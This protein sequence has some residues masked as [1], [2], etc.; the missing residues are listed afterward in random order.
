MQFLGL[1]LFL[2][3]I[4][5]VVTII[6]TGMYIGAL[7]AIT[8]VFISIVIGIVLFKISLAKTKK[9]KLMQSLNKGTFVDDSGFHYLISAVLFIMPGFIS[10]IL[11]IL[12]LIK[13]IQIY[14]FIA[15]LKIIT[16]FYKKFLKKNYGYFQQN[17]NSEFGFAEDL[18]K[19]DQDTKPNGK[20]YDAKF[21]V[22]VDDFTDSKDMIEKKSDRKE[23]KRDNKK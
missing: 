23:N 14:F 21:D 9:D 15:L 13:P 20:V 2:F 7:N 5:D 3:F 16:F 10:D 8:L 19:N 1:S 12:L 18:F 22:E 6:A 4:L 17:L 11:A